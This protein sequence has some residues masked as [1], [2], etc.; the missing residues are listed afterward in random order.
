V[1]RATPPAFFAGRRASYHV[2][3]SLA[4][5]GAKQ[6]GPLFSRHARHDKN[7]VVQL[8]DRVTHTLRNGPNHAQTTAQSRSVR[9]TS[10]SV[11]RKR[12][13]RDEQRDV[14][15]GEGAQPAP[16][17]ACDFTSRTT[18]LRQKGIGGSLE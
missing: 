11:A 16:E 18:L 5:A 17:L 12:P 8:A 14:A 6:H 15:E 3:C 1:R 9:R 4:V 10:V 7:Y 2:K 13:E